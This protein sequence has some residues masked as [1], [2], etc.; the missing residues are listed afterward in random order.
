MKNGLFI[1]EDLIIPENEI[2]VTTSR[3]GG[4]GG[5]HVNKA[6]TK[7]TVRWNVNQSI[8]LDQIQKDRIKFNLKNKITKDGDIIISNSE[9]RSQLQN[10]EN[11]LKILAKTIKKGLHIP[12]KR[13][14]TR[15]PKKEKEKRLKEKK[16][17]SEI[18]KMRSKKFDV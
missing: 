10:K 9:S 13:M 5:Q 18:K 1:K 17:R 6:E 2:E 16:Y 12:K 8:T 7:V 14:K 15:I 4:A 11:A 3:S